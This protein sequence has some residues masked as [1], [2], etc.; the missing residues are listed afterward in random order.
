MRIRNCLIH[1]TL[2]TLF[3]L[4][5]MLICGSGS[6]SAA[7]IPIIQ[8]TSHR[9]ALLADGKHS[10][11]LQ[12]QVRDS[13]GRSVPDNTSVQFSTNAGSLSPASAPTR[14]GIATVTLTSSQIAGLA[15]ISAFSSGGASNT[16]EILFTDD[17]E[18]TFGGNS[19][20][21]FST[22]SYLAYS[23]TDKVIEANGKNSGAKLNYRSLSLSADR[24]Q[25]RCEDLIVRAHGNVV[26]KRGGQTL[27]A[28]RLYYSLLNGEGYAMTEVNGKL[29]AV[30]ISGENLRIEPSK[31]VIP[32]SYI[33]MPE[34]QVKLVIAARGITYF[35]NEKLQFVKPKFFQDQTQIL[36]LPYYEL[37][38]YSQELFSDQFLSVGTSGFGLSLPIYYGLSPRSSGIVYLRHQQQLGRGYYSTESG[39]AVDVIQGYNSQ[40]DKR[41]EGAFGFT[42][43]TRS[44]WGFRWNHNVEIGNGTQGSFYFE[45]PHHDSLYSSANF[46]QQQKH[47]RIGANFS[48]GQ[49][50]ASNRT[51]TSRSDLFVETQPHRLS[52]SKTYSYTVGTTLAMGQ[53][54][55]KE[56][57]ISNYHE[58]TE[59]VNLRAFTRP[60][61]IDP[62]TTFTNSFSVGHTWSDTGG[63]GVAALASFSLDH[64]MPGGGTANITY[65]FVTQ[66]RAAF[67][68]GGNHRVSGTMAFS[69]SRKLSLSI[70][71]TA[72]LD[73]NQAS[74]IADMS[75][76]LDKKWRVLGA[77]TLQ[78][79]DADT[80]ND[81]EFTIGRQIGARELQVTY[82]TN[83]HR[84]SVDFTATRF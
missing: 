72:Y 79:F 53:T 78:R 34:L 43:L 56:T 82:S 1:T 19:Y 35:P 39:W 74:V 66:P 69:Q 67:N 4:N 49:T 32:G 61:A 44:D 12:A 50:F 22:S 8:L 51:T 46:S 24:L 7:G 21:A 11:V 70:F 10:T 2:L 57:G 75:Y 83:R 42:G 28:T 3:F 15:R 54:S 64:T 81:I 20:V 14:S 27:N 65:D 31:T 45:L 52:G 16:L 62:R 76:R 5:L 23:S 37:S 30:T 60:I 13:S 84:F 71:G 33:T 29:Q 9:S 26:V 40:G 41:Y 25:M 55:S 18:A 80:F 6:V 73:A 17:P 59:N 48:G 38:L 58:T 36:A 68:A 77:V 47:I 63:T